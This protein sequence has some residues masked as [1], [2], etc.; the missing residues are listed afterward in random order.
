M[1][2]SEKLDWESHS[3]DIPEETIAKFE[4]NFSIT[5]VKLSTQEILV[6]QVPMIPEKLTPTITQN[7]I[8]FIN[9]K[10]DQTNPID[11]TKIIINNIFPDNSPIKM[12]ESPPKIVES[13]GLS[14]KESSRSDAEIRMHKSSLRGKSPSPYKEPKRVSF[15]NQIMVVYN[16]QKN[17]GAPSHFAKSKKKKGC[18]CGG[19]FKI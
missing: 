18:S 2:Y 16:E 17:E 8:F 15:S 12:L 4:P 6:L 19:L 5:K 7:N 3:L 1:S 14:K 10:G 11:N 13:E 9:S